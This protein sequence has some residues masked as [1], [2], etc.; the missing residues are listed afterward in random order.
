MNAG[1]YRVVRALGKG[2]MGAIYLAQNTQ[3]FDRLCVIKEM[4]AYYEPGEEAKAQA[5]FEEEARTLAALKHPGIP[6]M[7]GYFSEAGHNYIVME[8]I[9]GDDFEKLVETARSRVSTRNSA[10]EVGLPEEDVV[11]YGVEICRVLEYLAHVKPQPVVHCD[12][13]PANIIVDRNS[14][15]A[16]LVDFGTARARYAPHS[17]APNEQRPSVY[18]TVGYAA[19]EMF[20]GQA[21]PKSDVFALANT[22]YYLLTGDDPRDHPFQ[23]PQMERLPAALHL[24][25]ER[26]LTEKANERLDAEQFRQQLEAYRASKAGTI[27][28]LTFPG[29]NQA[30][31]VTGVLDLAMKYWEYARQI[32]Y[33]GSLDTWLRQVAHDPVAADRA[34][35]AIKEYPAAQDAGLDTFVRSLNPRMPAPRLELIGSSIPGKSRVSTTRLLLVNHGPGGAQG[36]I[37]GSGPEVHPNANTYVLA[38]GAQ[39]EFDIQLRGRASSPAFVTV[40]P[41]VGQ[42]L[43]LDLHSGSTITPAI[44][45]RPPK[46]VQPSPVAP[47]TG[48]TTAQKRA[49]HAHVTS[50]KRPAWFI[51]A[52]LL[53][54][55]IALTIA[56]IS[57]LTPGSSSVDAGLAALQSGD[58]DKAQRILSQVD[59][60]DA[61][62][63][64]LVST[65]LN[66]QMIALDGGTL[67]M[68]LEEGSLD[69]R[70]VHAVEIAA[71]SMDRLEVTNIQYQQ[72]VNETGHATPSHWSAGHYAR[73]QALLPVVNVS[74]DD[75]QAYAAWAN[76]RLPTEAEWEWAARGAEGRLYPWG[77]DSD[78]TRVNT[79]DRGPGKLTD[80]GSYPLGTT[81]EGILDLGG[82]VRE[83]TADYYGPYLLLHA[84]PTEGSFVSVRG[85]SWRSSDDA[86]TA[87][88][89]VLS[90]E[91]ADDLGFRCAR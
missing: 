28:P 66:D 11:R 79:A 16:V 27:Q 23:W 73:G 58:W 18:G 4:L 3:A 55:A 85:S 30:T 33:D 20:A 41:S 53:F 82:N 50:R 35:E 65:A 49:P 90:S 56:L 12:I 39:I 71:F 31:T 40:T 78:P 14:Q 5:R 1:Q 13:K 15:Q 51:W 84:P 61:T 46:P 86:A 6:D 70:P 81:P 8:Y 37:I 68:G 75:A 24:I 57:A 77:N 17:T 52:I 67:S 10:S 91:T 2:G 43:A 36:S 62:A 42:P 34:R 69:Q 64:A 88:Q 87:R 21:V 7:Y 19:P 89:K 74:W 48:R 45:P 38:P 32:L 54:A 76:K 80:V 83:W 47:S 59:P 9:E 25:L 44:G 60:S 63:V 29:G 72:F 26:A 22:L